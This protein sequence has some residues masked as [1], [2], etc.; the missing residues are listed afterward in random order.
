MKN[1]K[2]YAICTTCLTMIILLTLCIMPIGAV[3]SEDYSFSV[4]DTTSSGEFTAERFWERSN[5]AQAYIL[6]TYQPYHDDMLEDAV[7]ERLSYTPVNMPQY[8]VPTFPLGQEVYDSYGSLDTITTMNSYT[9]NG[10]YYP[11]LGGSVQLV[12]LEK[13]TA[14]Q[15][16]IQYK[17][18]T[19]PTDRFAQGT[20]EL[21]VG[22]IYSAYEYH[23]YTDNPNQVE[24]NGLTIT[25]QSSG[26]V[27]VYL[28]GTMDWA[29]EANEEYPETGS[30]AI[31]SYVL[32]NPNYSVTID[33]TLIEGETNGVTPI[34]TR[35]SGT[36][37]VRYGN[38]CESSVLYTENFNDY[39]SQCYSYSDQNLVGMS[40]AQDGKNG[41]FSIVRSW[42][43]QQY[44]GKV[45]EPIPPINPTG[46]LNITENGSYYVRN[47]E[48]VSVNVP[49]SVEWSGMIDWIFDSIG[50]FL[51]FEI[52]PD[53]SVGTLMTLVVGLA[54]AI[55]AIRV[56]MG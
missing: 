42:A 49:Q 10:S 13:T 23:P 7:A 30:V 25:N 47:Y 14:T 53:W 16:V 54:V 20:R 36:I 19:T 24:L 4:G 37:M 17:L 56:F 51:D 11:I 48:T 9:V 31:D 41:G 27:V 39:Y 26:T 50:A 44:M 5:K 22:D 3:Y 33:R 34:M 21:W 40:N 46:N 1:K 38:D 12:K 43:M 28:C 52:A 18:T 15:G 35:W 32:L 45:L 6:P 29:G 2:I 8:V 55:W